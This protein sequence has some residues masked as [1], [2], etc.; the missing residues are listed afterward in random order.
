[1]EYRIRIEKR[2]DSEYHVECMTEQF[3]RVADVTFPDAW[4]AEEY[5]GRTAVA[6]KAAGHCVFVEDPNY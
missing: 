1:M 5:A 2:T 6:F 3:S 4:E